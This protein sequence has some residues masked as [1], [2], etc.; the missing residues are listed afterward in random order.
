MKPTAPTHVPAG[1]LIALLAAALTLA[2][3]PPVALADASYSQTLAP[4]GSLSTGSTVSPSEPVQLTVTAPAGGDFTI[5]EET[6]P[7]QPLQAYVGKVAMDWVGPQFSLATPN[8]AQGCNPAQQQAAAQTLTVTALVDGASL[9]EGPTIGANPQWR[10]DPQAVCANLDGPVPAFC[11]AGR[12][13]VAKLCWTFS[14][15]LAVCNDSPGFTPAEIRP[16]LLPDGNVEIAMQVKG[17]TSA[18]LVFRAGYEP[19]QCAQAGGDTAIVDSRDFDHGNLDDLI[20]HG[21][22]YDDGCNQRTTVSG[23]LT[24]TGAAA[25]KLRLHSTVVGRVSDG[26]GDGTIELTP[27]A[28]SAF[29][30]RVPHYID[31]RVALTAHGAQPGES[32][33]YTETLSVKRPGGGGGIG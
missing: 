12:A 28:K 19:F 4:G 30:R 21:V 29:R 24:V 7:A 6:S 9:P 14:T 18:P 8:C 33:S 20:A 2:S 13:A 11:E 1:A 31:V 10:P 17:G 25:R 16:Q 23:T 22:Y 32:W 5:G 26:P 15:A 27:A 3:A